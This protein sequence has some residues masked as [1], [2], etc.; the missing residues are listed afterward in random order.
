LGAVELLL[1]ESAVLLEESAVPLETVSDNGISPEEPL[2]SD[3]C[4][5]SLLVSRVVTL[6][7]VPQATRKKREKRKYDFIFLRIDIY[8][9]NNQ[10][11]P[12]YCAF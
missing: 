6:S 2:I 5:L 12:K 3:D 4:W 8:E 1:G 11:V 7:V 9:M 10:R